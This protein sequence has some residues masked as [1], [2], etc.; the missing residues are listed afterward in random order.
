MRPNENWVSEITEILNNNKIYPALS[1]FFTNG[2]FTRCRRRNECNCVMNS[3]LTLL[4]ENCS[5]SIVV[6]T[7]TG[8]CFPTDDYAIGSSISLR[9]IPQKKGI[10][11]SELD[12]EFEPD[13]SDADRLKDALEVFFVNEYPHKG[14]ILLICREAHF[15]M[16][17]NLIIAIKTWYPHGD[18]EIWGGK[19]KGINISTY[20]VEKHICGL[21]IECFTMLLRGPQVKVWTLVLDNYPYTNDKIKNELEIFKRTISMKRHS[22]GLLFTKTI[23]LAFESKFLIFQE[24]FTNIP[25]FEICGPEA[26]GT[27]LPAFPNF[28]CNISPRMVFTLLTYNNFAN[29]HEY[30]QSLAHH[31]DV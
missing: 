9:A 25:M 13:F 3:G 14:F 16:A 24:V 15:D 26:F 17:K 20:T 6:Y 8:L 23:T 19:V 29:F 10:Y 4:I 18:A 5:P 22:V 27:T 21:P 2:R 11:C 31:I 28:N 7:L 30:Y 1:M 12:D